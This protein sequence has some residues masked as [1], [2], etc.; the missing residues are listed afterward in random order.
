M[1]ERLLERIISVSSNPGDLV[2]DPFSGSGTTCVAAARLGRTYFGID[3]SKEYVRQSR[4][5]IAETLAGRR[6]TT[7]I[8]EAPETLRATRRTRAS[9]K[10]SSGAD[11]RS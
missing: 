5:R 6:K 8:S 7:E 1:P 11:G 4:K 9:R 2:L 10:Q 3:I